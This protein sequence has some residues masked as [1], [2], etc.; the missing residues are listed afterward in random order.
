MPSVALAQGFG[1]IGACWQDAVTEKKRPVLFPL[2]F[3]RLLLH[4]MGWRWFLRR[5]IPVFLTFFIMVCCSDFEKPEKRW[6]DSGGVSDFYSAG[7]FVLEF[8]RGDLA[9]GSV[10]VLSTSQ[11][12]SVF[13]FLQ[14][15]CCWYREDTL[16]VI[17]MKNKAY[18]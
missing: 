12:I 11:F 18:S 10:G 4:Q 13:T 15:L 7:R 6:R 2:R 3:I 1:R 9:R 5:F 17:E 8:F 16:Q 14:E